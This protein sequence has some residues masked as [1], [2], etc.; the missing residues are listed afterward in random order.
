MNGM[1]AGERVAVRAAADAAVAAFARRSEP[2]S[3]LAS[4]AAEVARAAYAMAVR[5][6]R[7]GRLL[8]FGA[9]AASTDAQHVAVEFIHPVIVG[10]RALPAITLTAD[11]ATVTAVAAR[12]GMA[13][14]FAYQIEQLGRP[15]DM[16]L[17][18]SRDGNCQ[19]VLDGLLT[20]SERGMLTIALAGGADGTSGAIGASLVADHLLVTASAD[21]LV[22]KEMQVTTY[23]I[24]WELVHVFLEQPSALGPG[25]P[26]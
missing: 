18:I 22:V 19:S 25:A 20:A 26:P 8:S 6:Y 7:G 15:A 21:P 13:R 17:G 16:A 9:G 4:Q 24:L 3:G 14:A 10:K 1:T 12:Q 23:H 5:F 11:G 2:L